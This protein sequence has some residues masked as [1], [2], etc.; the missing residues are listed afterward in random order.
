MNRETAGF[1]M[2]PAVTRRTWMITFSDLISLLLAFFVL[3]FSMYSVKFDRWQ[4][5]V[6]S[7]SEALNPK[8]ADAVAPFPSPFNIGK[9]SRKRIIDLDYLATLLQQSL[10]SDA[11]LVESHIMRRADRLIVALPGDLLFDPGRAV[12]SERS[13]DAVFNLG[14]ILRS[15]GN[16]IGVNGHSDPTQLNSPEYASNWELSLARAA[17][18]ANTLRRSGYEKDIVAYGFADG[19]YRDLPPM[20]EAQRRA[21]A[22]RV[23]IVVFATAEAP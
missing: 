2:K 16:R 9:V 4:S 14:G 12:L 6:D 11:L 5:T 17:A 10:K 13:R 23:D 7:L 20:N 1:P 8:R 22:R 15:L 18:V 3:L 21:L 19:R